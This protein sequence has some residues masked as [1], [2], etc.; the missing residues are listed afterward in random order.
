MDPLPANPRTKP[1]P[2]GSR[3]A[4]LGGRKVVL[5]SAVIAT[6]VL[7]AVRWSSSGTGAEE[8]HEHSALATV[9]ADTQV[10]GIQ[11]IVFHVQGMFCESCESTI[12]TMLKRTPGVVRTTVSAKL[13]KAV[14]DYQPAHTSPAKLV[15]VIRSLGYTVT[16]P[17]A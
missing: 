10:A 9:P 1:S 11:R 12:T 5:A 15:E 14:V 2:A 16:I 8:P 6:A 7:A 4:R 17:R 3:G 13:A